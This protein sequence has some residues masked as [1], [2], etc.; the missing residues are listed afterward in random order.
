MAKKSAPEK[1]LCQLHVL[2]TKVFTMALENIIDAMSSDDP[3]T[4]AIA[5]SMVNPS[6]LNA[7]NAF[8]KNNEITC[9]PEMLTELTNTE[10]RLKEK[11]KTR[12]EMPSF[13]LDEMQEFARQ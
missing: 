4:K 7:I 13:D 8:L 6:L 2:Q 11:L 10:R 1:E 9:Q 5:M 12:T 3:E